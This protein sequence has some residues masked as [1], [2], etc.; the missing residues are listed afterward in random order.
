VG[1]EEVI[2][3][4][5][6]DTSLAF[7]INFNNKDASLA[8]FIICV[9]LRPLPSAVCLFLQKTDRYLHDLESC[10]QVILRCI[11]V[12]PSD[13]NDSASSV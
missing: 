4:N 12:H 2:N 7:V 5:N 8:F 1:W 13:S 10:H 9:R 6:K 3:I 11:I